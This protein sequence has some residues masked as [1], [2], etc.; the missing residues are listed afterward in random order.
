MELQLLIK[1]LKKFAHIACL[2]ERT[3]MAHQILDGF[4][5]MWDEGDELDEIKETLRGEY[6]NNDGEKIITDQIVEM[7]IKNNLPRD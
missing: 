5:Y 7:M 4:T 1:N 6:L 2:K 3:D